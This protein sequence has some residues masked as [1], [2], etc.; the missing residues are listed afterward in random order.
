MTKVISIANRKG[1]VGK[2]STAI[3][4]AHALVLNKENVLLIDSDSQGNS[5]TIL[6][7]SKY[8]TSRCL[9]DCLRH[10]VNILD[11]IQKTRISN[12]DILVNNKAHLDLS[13]K[14]LFSFKKMLD[15]L[16]TSSQYNYIII[17]CSPNLNFLLMGIFIASNYII[18]PV[19][20]DQFSIHGMNDIFSTYSYVKG[21]YN[22]NL[23]VLGVFINL[24][25]QREKIPVKIAKELSSKLKDLNFD[26]FQSTIPRSST[27]NKAQV[28]NKTIFEYDQKSGLCN[29][30]MRFATE[31][32]E[33]IEKLN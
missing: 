21:N 32:I 24:Y 4:L 27:M 11:C 31:V 14:T 13:M 19:L 3:N 22:A 10:K 8:F 1:G 16:V 33:A 2:T 17:D 26:F 20:P 15:E 28:N 23:E 30:Y 12:L 5:S 9:A 6:K 18:I 7:T 29:A 25:N